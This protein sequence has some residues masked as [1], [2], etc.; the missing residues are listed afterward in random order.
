MFNL[1]SAQS[2]VS[3]GL[4][5]RGCLVARDQ[6]ERNKVFGIPRGADPHARQGEEPQRFLGVA[7]DWYGPADWGWLR[8]V[9]HPV[10]ACKRWTLRRRLGP[11]APDDDEG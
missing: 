10:K 9:R 2:Q 11:Y 8:S 4:L 6:E 7:V 5:Q 3:P 1:S